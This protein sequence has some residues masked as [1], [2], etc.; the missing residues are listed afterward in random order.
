MNSQWLYSSSQ[1]KTGFWKWNIDLR[2]VNPVLLY[3]IELWRFPNL[4]WLQ[5]SISHNLGL[6]G[7]LLLVQMCD[8]V[9]VHKTFS[10]LVLVIDRA[11]N[12]KDMMRP[13]QQKFLQ[14]KASIFS[15]DRSFNYRRSNISSWAWKSKHS[16]RHENVGEDTK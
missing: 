6:F 1:L 3:S 16:Y 2:R 15:F 7:D 13:G 8:T 12:Y 14:I 10:P 11:N 9:V 4:V 5:F